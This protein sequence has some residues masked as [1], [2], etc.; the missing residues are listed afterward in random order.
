[1][2]EHELT[3]ACMLNDVKKLQE[4]ISSGHDPNET[5]YFGIAPVENAST[6]GS[7]DC[8]MLLLNL[9]VPVDNP[10]K[11]IYALNM[12]YNVNY[13]SIAENT[14]NVKRIVNNILNTHE[15]DVNARISPHH[16]YSLLGS[17]CVSGFYEIAKLLLEHGADPDSSD[18]TICHPLMLAVVNGFC[19]ITKLL[20]TYGAC[21]NLKKQHVSVLHAAVTN[22]SIYTE[23]LYEVGENTHMLTVS[24]AHT[25]PNFYKNMYNF[26]LLL[27]Y[28]ARDAIPK[29]A[30]DYI[31][32]YTYKITEKHKELFT[33]VN[34]QEKTAQLFE[35]IKSRIIWHKIKHSLWYQNS[36]ETHYKPGGIGYKLAIHEF[37]EFMKEL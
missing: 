37:N 17:A 11:L 13:Q 6:W 30:V 8:L 16:N 4:L 31:S 15:V 34:V 1:M 21:A 24:D 27:Q 9:E 29:R 7:I 18:F 32:K 23:S 2:Y 19:D 3:G 10:A 35:N 12:G 22:N 36:M 5:D 28:G 20:L 14:F 25:V 26:I 33:D